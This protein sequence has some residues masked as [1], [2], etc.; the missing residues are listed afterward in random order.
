MQNKSLHRTRPQLLK[1]DVQRSSLQHG[2][3]LLEAMIAV[4][5]FSFGILA[6]SGLQGAMMKNTAEA[7]YRSEAAY[8]VQQ[9][10]GNMLANPIALGGG[11]F[12]V[13]TLPSGSLVITPITQSRLRF[14]VTWQNPGENVHQYE[15]IT[16]VFMA[17]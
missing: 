2:A 8:I 4:L 10:I 7:T 16:T 1:A 14:V 13:A 6:L 15:A 17:R 3:I 5:I 12:P 9:R 11:T